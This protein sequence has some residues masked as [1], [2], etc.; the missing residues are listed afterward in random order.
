MNKEY[1]KYKDKHEKHAEVKMISQIG[2][3]L[4]EKFNTDDVIVQGGN[5][6]KAN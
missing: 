3:L 4:S 5:A 1:I 2:K 6:K